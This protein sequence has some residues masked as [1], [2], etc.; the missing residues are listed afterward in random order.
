[1]QNLFIINRSHLSPS[2]PS[3]ALVAILSSFRMLG[4][5]LPVYTPLQPFY[6][7][8]YRPLGESGVALYNFVAVLYTRPLLRRLVL[9][10]DREPRVVIKEPKMR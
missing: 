4:Y 5:T 9:H 1:M 8:L 7:L 2:A 6:T 3:R 10:R